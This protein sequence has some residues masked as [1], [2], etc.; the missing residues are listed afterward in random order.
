MQGGG[1][2]GEGDSGASLHPASAERNVI[3]RKGAMTVAENRQSTFG[4]DLD[5]GYFVSGNLAK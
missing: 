5:T 4:D 2:V 1:W 3:H